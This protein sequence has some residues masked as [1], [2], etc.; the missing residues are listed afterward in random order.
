M[1]KRKVAVAWEQVEMFYLFDSVEE[2][3]TSERTWRNAKARAKRK[4]WFSLG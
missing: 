2:W 1:R 4:S 3:Q